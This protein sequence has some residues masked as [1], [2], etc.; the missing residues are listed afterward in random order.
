MVRCQ[1]TTTSSARKPASR[2]RATA[3]RSYASTADDTDRHPP[4]PA[5]TTASCRRARPRPIPWCDGTTASIVIRAAHGSIASVTVR[6]TPA[7]DPS[8]Y[9]INEAPPSTRGELSASPARAYV[10][11]T[12]PGRRCIAELTMFAQSVDRAGVAGL[13]WV[14]TGNPGGKRSW[15]RDG[16]GRTRVRTH[17]TPPRQAP[18]PHRPRAR[19]R[20]RS[21]D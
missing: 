13:V 1:Q 20:T 10:M 18:H 4:R 9:A 21:R 6:T 14:P 17:R 7:G 8:R 3:R 16:V 12:C 19:A 15:G 11:S 2:Q 5:V